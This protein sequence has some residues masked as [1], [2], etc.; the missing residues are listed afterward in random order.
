MSI[1]EM[2]KQRDFNGL[3]AFYE[4]LVRTADTDPSKAVADAREMLDQLCVG[5]L[6]HKKQPLQKPI[7]YSNVVNLLRSGNAGEG[8][9]ANVL[10]SKISTL[11][12]AEAQ[13]KDTNFS[14]PALLPGT[15][16]IAVG[17][18]HLIMLQAI[19][20]RVLE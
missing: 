11:E 5:Y 4:G 17:E 13:I 2:I 3:Q 19:V 12:E 6:A 10:E 16:K 7:S 20:C 9:L 18:T 1:I 14:V 15:A 8:R